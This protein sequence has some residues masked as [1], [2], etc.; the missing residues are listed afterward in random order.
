MLPLVLLQLFVG[1]HE[2]WLDQSH[3]NYSQLL[4]ASVI[5]NVASAA[6]TIFAWE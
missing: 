4:A 3:A 2:A 6:F 5:A 1:V